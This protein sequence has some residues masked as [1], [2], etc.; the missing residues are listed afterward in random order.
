M[1]DFLANIC[2]GERVSVG[3][4]CDVASAHGRHIGAVPVS[5]I[6]R[7]VGT[8]QIPDC[9]QLISTDEWTIRLWRSF[10]FS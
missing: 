10:S 7:S 4:L 5:D 2:R 9:P 3:I 6:G 8:G 1:D